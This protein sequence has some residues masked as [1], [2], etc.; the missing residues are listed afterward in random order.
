MPEL[1]NS[2]TTTTVAS[3]LLLTLTLTGQTTTASILYLLTLAAW[4][5]VEL[6]SSPTAVALTN[7]PAKS[8]KKT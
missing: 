4:T 2:R 7:R 6:A 5:S 1:A 3:S 8:R